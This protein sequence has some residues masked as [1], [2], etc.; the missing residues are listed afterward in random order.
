MGNIEPADA[1]R[2]SPVLS[3]GVAYGRPLGRQ[4]GSYKGPLRQTLASVLRM[5][6]CGG[7][8]PSGSENE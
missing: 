2:R 5:S 4:W 6:I 8:L 1:N 7:S 3:W